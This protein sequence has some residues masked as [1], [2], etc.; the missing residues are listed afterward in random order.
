MSAGFLSG[1]YVPTTSTVLPFRGLVQHPEQSFG[2]G[3]GHERLVQ[4]ISDSLHRVEK[5]IR[6]EKEHHEVADFHVQPTVPAQGAE[7]AEVSYH[8]LDL[9]EPSEEFTVA[10]YQRAARIAAADRSAPHSLTM[11]NASQRYT[12]DA[13]SLQDATVRL[14]GNALTLGPGDRVPRAT[15]VPAS[16]GILTMAPATITF[17]AVPAAANAACG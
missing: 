1:S 10:Q 14:N 17:L 6:E 4:L 2:A 15:G 9:V 16:A 12:L 3:H 5:Q 11:A 8:L 7:R 13:A